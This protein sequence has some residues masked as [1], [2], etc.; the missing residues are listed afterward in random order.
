MLKMSTTFSK[1]SIHP[2]LVC[3]VFLGQCWQQSVQYCI[4][5]PPS[6]VG[7]SNK[8]SRMSIRSAREHTMFAPAQLLRFYN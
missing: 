2:F 8:L 5:V 4:S 3:E 7:Y 6:F 1:T